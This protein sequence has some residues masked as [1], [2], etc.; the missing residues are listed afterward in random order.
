M[1]KEVLEFNKENLE[2]LCNSDD[3][4]FNR[5]HNFLSNFEIKP[6]A[7][8]VCKRTK[9][10]KGQSCLDVGCGGGYHSVLMALQGGKVTALEIN[11]I[12]I[13]K[14]VLPL[15]KENGVKI[16]TIAL[17]LLEAKLSE[18]YDW[19]VANEVIEHLVSPYK[20]VTKI[21]S[22]LKQNGRFV[23]TIPNINSFFWR[24]I[25]FVEKTPLWKPQLDV[26]G[27]EIHK[28]F[29]KKEAFELVKDFEIE[30]Y[31]TLFS[32]HLFVLKKKIKRGKRNDK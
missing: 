16:K 11:P 23:M 25:K 3:M 5:K 20:G 4:R 15:A 29:T 18:K 13:K 27:R 32:S 26:A 6:R 30:E 12:Y 31:K 9:V 7:Y 24:L 17:G 1:N 21:E 22:L 10:Q 28:E 8:N 2:R 19:I 14:R